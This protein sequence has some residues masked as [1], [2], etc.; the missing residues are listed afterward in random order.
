MGVQVLRDSMATDNFAAAVAAGRP[1]LSTIGRSVSAPTFV[2]LAGMSHL[3]DSSPSSCSS[4]GSSRGSSRPNSR[5]LAST[6]HPGII[7]LPGQWCLA[8]SISRPDH[9]LSTSRVQHDWNEHMDTAL[10]AQRVSTAPLSAGKSE[11]FWGH[12]FRNTRD[13]RGR[14]KGVLT[15]YVRE[16]HSKFGQHVNV[17]K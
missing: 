9:F 14:K 10:Y 2:T 4:R 3:A 17:R 15:Q 1:M 6:I 11:D 13:W 7:N 8:P 12:G 16:V 5:G